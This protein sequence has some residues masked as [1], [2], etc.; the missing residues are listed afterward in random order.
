MKKIFVTTFNK[1]LYDNY[2]YKLIESYKQTEQTLPLYCYVE[3]DIDFYPK[4]KNVKFLNIYDSQPPCFDFVQRNQKKHSKFA[5][6]HFLLD[7][8]RFCYKVFAQSD[9]RKFGDHIFYID[10]DTEFI[11]KIPNEWYSECLP[12]DTFI[13]LH[14]RLGYYT[15]TGFL[16]INNKIT[17]KKGT[18]I[19]EEFFALY[20]K[21]YI[22]DLI[23]ALPAFTDCHALDATRMRFKFLNNIVLEYSPYKEKNLKVLSD[24]YKTN[25]SD[26]DLIKPYIIHKKG[27]IKNN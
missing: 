20:T 24:S 5:R 25:V 11:K 19:S 2:A 14:E 15:E 27:N 4:H 1:R 23:Y 9:S 21:Y 12:E 17:N 3:D 18:K 8:V 26:S 22:H 16:A 7:A 13:T 10:S 6:E